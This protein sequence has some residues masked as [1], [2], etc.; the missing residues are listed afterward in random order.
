ME[1]LKYHFITRKYWRTNEH[2]FRHLK[3]GFEQEDNLFSSLVR[4]IWVSYKIIT[5]KKISLKCTPGVEIHYRFLKLY[6]RFCLQ[7]TNINVLLY[8][9]KKSGVLYSMSVCGNHTHCTNGIILDST[10]FDNSV[11]ERYVFGY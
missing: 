4:V 9:K 5:R 3:R 11:I 6:E 2:T 1:V 8:I 10:G 7:K